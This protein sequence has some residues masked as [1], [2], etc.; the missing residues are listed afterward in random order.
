MAF[1]AARPFLPHREPAR[2]QQQHRHRGSRARAGRWVYAARRLP[3][4]RRQRDAYDEL[5]F[6]FIRDIAPVAAIFSASN[7]VYVHPSVPVKTIPELIAYIKANPGKLD[8]ASADNGSSS[9][10]AGELFK[11]MVGVDM[12]HVPYR[13]QGP[14]ITDLLGG[15][16]QVMFATT[17]ET[18]EYIAVGRLRPLAVTTARRVGALPDVPTVGEFV[19][20]Y[21]SS[22]WYGYGAP[23]NT[24]AGIIE[25]LNTEINAALA[26]SRMRARLA[27]FGGTVL[28][29]SP[30]DFGKIIA[31]ETE[32]WGKVIRAANIKPE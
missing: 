12:V 20:G 32:R 18:T 31:D 29:G 27:N 10:M 28:G 23:R 2:G 25:R 5:S 24:P 4:E 15:Q 11:M 17:P 6:N 16:V 3:C 9:H 13:G 14:A 30:A 19:T 8:M 22:Q 26:D 1:G 21:E 7:V